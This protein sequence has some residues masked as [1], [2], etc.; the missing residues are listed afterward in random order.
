MK[1]AV[2]KNQFNF[3]FLMLELCNLIYSPNI[4]HFLNQDAFTR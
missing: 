2:Q 4:K 3:L 1:R